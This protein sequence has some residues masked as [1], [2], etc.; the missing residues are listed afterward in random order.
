[1]ELIMLDDS[2]LVRYYEEI[3]TD[4]FDAVQYSVLPN[5][6]FSEKG[7]HRLVPLQRVEWINDTAIGAAIGSP[8]S[9]TDSKVGLWNYYYENG[10]DSAIGNYSYS[11]FDHA[12]VTDDSASGGYVLLGIITYR[13]IKTGTWNYYSREGKLI[14]RE[15][16]DK[17]NLLKRETF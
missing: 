1:M 5:G 11:C 14:R 7:F 12:S 3:A 2:G 13:E 4:S 8:G 6:Q 15:E 17:G 9:V 16:W 10:V